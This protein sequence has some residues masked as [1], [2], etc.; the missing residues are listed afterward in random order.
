[1]KDQKIVE[2]S[3]V[4]EVKRQINVNLNLNFLY[5]D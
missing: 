4:E 5:E 2:E 1:M 3:D